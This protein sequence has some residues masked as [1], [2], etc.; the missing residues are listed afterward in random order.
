MAKEVSAAQLQAAAEDILADITDFGDAVQ[1][2]IRNHT[3]G[4]ERT[5]TFTSKL[6]PLNGEIL[7][8]GS[9]NQRVLTIAQ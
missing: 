2:E 7:P 3:G 8:S 4:R 1:V 9:R 5:P 6:Q